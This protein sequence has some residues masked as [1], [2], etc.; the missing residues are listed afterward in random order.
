M[1][2]ISAARDEAWREHWEQ[3]F[4]DAGLSFESDGE[5]FFAA[6]WR[7]TPEGEEEESEV[8]D[9]CFQEYGH[10]ER[11]PRREEASVHE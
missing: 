4:S 5:D 2:S 10:T 1:G 9:Y 3:A 11:C 8:C 6:A 7:E